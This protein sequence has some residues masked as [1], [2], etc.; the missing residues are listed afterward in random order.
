MWKIKFSAHLTMLGLKDCLTPEFTSE[1]PAKEKDT[2]DLTSDKGKNWAHAVRKNKK[3]V[4]QCAL[5]WKKVAQL[6]KLN[7]ATRADKDWSSGKA[8]EVMIQL[9]KEYKPD[10]TMAKIEKEK[11]LNKFSKQ[12]ERSK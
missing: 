3:M 8:H 9:V 1:L 7:C 12:E 10:D 5:S 11:A 6:N 2:F 4:M